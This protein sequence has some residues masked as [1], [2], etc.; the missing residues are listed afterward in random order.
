MPVVEFTVEGPPISHQTKD[1]GILQAWQRTIRQEAARV[2][3]AP[4]LTGPVKFTMM[5]FYAA[6]RPQLDDDNMAKPIRDALSGLVYDDDG[7]ITHAEHSQT[8]IDAFF[9]IRGTSLVILEAFHRG[10]EFVYIRI[11]DAPTH[12]QLPK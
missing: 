7:Q 10:K 4:P 3:P 12:T 6:A 8:S 11:E 1:R 9:Q 2:W 5:N